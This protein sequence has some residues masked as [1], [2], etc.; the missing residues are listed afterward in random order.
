MKN[1]C[2]N[3]EGGGLVTEKTLYKLWKGLSPRK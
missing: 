3:T 2:T 1:N